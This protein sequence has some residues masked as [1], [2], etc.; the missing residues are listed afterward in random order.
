MEISILSNGGLLL[1]IDP[2]ER[3]EIR[4]QLQASGELSTLIDLAEPYWTNGGFQ[5]FDASAG[6]PFVGLTGAPCVAEAMSYDD[7]GKATVEGKLWWFPQYETV[8]LIDTL[9]DSL[10][11]SLPLAPGYA[12]ESIHPAA[13]PEAPPAPRLKM[14]R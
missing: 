1:S 13:E 2:D 14:R 8:G 3:E 12:F 7:E 10:S 5:P 6:N 4:D 11:V 9:L